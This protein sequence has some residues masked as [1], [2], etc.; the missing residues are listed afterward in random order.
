MTTPNTNVVNLNILALEPSKFKGLLVTWS[1]LTFFTTPG[2]Y[3]ILNSTVDILWCL[4][5]SNVTKTKVL[6]SLTI[7]FLLAVKWLE[8][9]FW[10][11][12]RS[13]NYQMILQFL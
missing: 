6:N 13:M 4:M 5:S 11:L 9:K 8:L 10:M 2:K 3:N 1:Y 12:Q 7:I